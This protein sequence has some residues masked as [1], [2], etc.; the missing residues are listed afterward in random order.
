VGDDEFAWPEIF[1]GAHVAIGGALQYYGG[2]LP[3]TGLFVGFT[4]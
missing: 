2:C 4:V 1:K 3:L